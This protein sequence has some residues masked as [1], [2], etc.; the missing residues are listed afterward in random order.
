MPQITCS[1]LSVQ[2]KITDSDS[3]I[4]TRRALQVG[5]FK[6]PQP[7]IVPRSSSRGQRFYAPPRWRP[8]W[9]LRRCLL[10]TRHNITGQK[11]FLTIPLESQYS[12]PSAH[13]VWTSTRPPSSPSSFLNRALEGRT[14]SARVDFC[15]CG[16]VLRAHDDW[17]TLMQYI[18]RVWVL[19]YDKATLYVCI[20]LR[21]PRISPCHSTR[22]T[23]STATMPLSLVCQRHGRG[24]LQHIVMASGSRLQLVHS[25]AHEPGRATSR[26][27]ADSSVSITNTS[28]VSCVLL[29]RQ[30]DVTNLSFELA[31]SIQQSRHVRR[32]MA[33]L[34]PD[35]KR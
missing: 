1:R 19:A 23:V 30:R 34:P 12:V 22:H 4:L 6:I 16:M 3:R 27:I 31:L 11:V 21:A 18:K 33:A 26:T 20:S 17:F 5:M 2:I 13:L 35:P 28:K 9:S 24:D 25:W 10:E 29:R 8:R 15:T 32:C 7:I 14:L